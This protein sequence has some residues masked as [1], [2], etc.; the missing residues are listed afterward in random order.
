M[1]PKFSIPEHDRQV[2][3][4]KHDGLLLRGHTEL[5]VHCVVLDLHFVQVVIVHMLASPVQV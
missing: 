2:E 1:I 5:V 4:L 3:G